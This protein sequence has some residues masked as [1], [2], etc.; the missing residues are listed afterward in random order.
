MIAKIILGIVG[1]VGLGFTGTYMAGQHCSDG[2][3]PISRLLNG[4]GGSDC[5]TEGKDCCDPPQACCGTAKAKEEEKVSAKKVPSCCFPG[6]PCCEGG[7][8]CLKKD[9]K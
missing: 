7:D 2:G 6:S 1:L 8:C 4:S 9:S 5:C 3:C